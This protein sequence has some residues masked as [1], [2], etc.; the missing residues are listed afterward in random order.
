MANTPYSN[1]FLENEIE[2]QFN[3]HLDMAQFCTVDDSLTAT[4]GM[5]V[6]VHVYS[7]TSGTEDLTKGQGNTKSIEVGYDEKEY[8]VK[9]AQNRF[10]YYD[11]EEMTDPMIVTAGIQ[12]AGTDMF[13][14]ECGDIYA[15]FKKAQ[16]TVAAQ[17]FDF[18]SFVDA[19]SLLNFEDGDKQETFA[20]VSPADNAAIRKSLKDE[21]KYVE[22]FARQGYVGTVAGT[23]L[24]IKK[25]IESGTIVL[26]TKEAVKLI[27]KKGVEVEQDRD[28][29]TRK[30]TIVS[31]KAY[32]AAFADA[33][34]AVKIIK[35]TASV[36]NDTTVSAD[37]TYYKAVGLGYVVA[38]TKTG[39]NPKTLGLYEIA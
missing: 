22:A 15:E 11:E 1:F 2:D 26:A 32:V 27:N 30:N 10:V 4:P 38:E 16:L 14:H 13:N 20:F 37:K 3:S 24:Y 28:I 23:N 18:N 19:Q 25:D 5:K 6:K 7:A 12:H 17:N 8:E 34:R 33:T 29:D 9:L 36:T 21:L 39:D 35:G 31:R